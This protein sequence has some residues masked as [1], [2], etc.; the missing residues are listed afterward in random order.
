MMYSTTASEEFHNKFNKS[1]DGPN[2][3][4]IF[5][6]EQNNNDDE[7]S[8]TKASQLLLTTVSSKGVNIY[9][10]TGGGF[11]TN[12]NCF[13]PT[14]NEIPVQPVARWRD[15]LIDPNYHPSDVTMTQ[16]SFNSKS[17]LH[18][19]QEHASTLLKTLQKAAGNGNEAHPDPLLTS[20]PT[21]YKSN[22]KSK[23]IVSGCDYPDHKDL[24]TNQ[25]ASEMKTRYGFGDPYE[26]S[27]FMTT[28]KNDKQN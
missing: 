14:D 28:L 26:F 20:H 9:K 8:S 25:H 17:S 3:Y 12:N 6:K 7:N 23:N 21:G 11:K 27:Q 16:S 13:V 1:L 2:N 10:G 24:T 22:Y 5:K 15:R 18:K 19:E 4:A